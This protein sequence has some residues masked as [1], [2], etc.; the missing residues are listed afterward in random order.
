MASFDPS[1]AL[2]DV[3]TMDD[4]LEADLAGS[5]LLLR[6]MNGFSA[7]A[8][9]LAGLGIW[10]VIAQLVAQRSREIGVRV[11]LGAT[12]RQVLT[13]V[14]RLGVLPVAGGL[15][16]GLAAGLG[17]AR[18]MRSLLFQV[19][20]TDPLTIGIACLLLALVAALAVVGPARRAAR[21]DPLAALRDE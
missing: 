2:Y 3:R 14:A 19:T 17:L 16:A 8:L 4:V 6:V 1:Q 20:P 7:L 13:L 15:L 18:L 5:R 9:G 12:T 11:A 21:L 10:G